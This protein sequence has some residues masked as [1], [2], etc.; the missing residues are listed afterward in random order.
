VGD[1]GL[2]CLMDRHKLDKTTLA[3]GTFGNMAPKLPYMGKT[4]KESDVY[5]F[6]ILVL[7]VV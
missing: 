6:G 7:E 5:S 1:F 4:T 2:A 3:P